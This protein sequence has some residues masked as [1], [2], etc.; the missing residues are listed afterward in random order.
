MSRLAAG[1]LAYG[2]A[3]CCVLLLIASYSERVP[4]VLVAQPPPQIV[5]APFFDHRAPE[6]PAVVDEDSADNQDDK[7][8]ILPGQFASPGQLRSVYP[9]YYLPN[10][11]SSDSWNDENGFSWSPYGHYSK[12]FAVPH[13][14]GPWHIPY[15]FPD[16]RKVLQKKKNSFRCAVRDDLQEH[17]CHTN[18][19]LEA[20]APKTKWFVCLYVLN[21]IVFLFSIYATRIIVIAV[22]ETR[23]DPGRC[24]NS[25]LI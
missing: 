1:W 10:A 24:A 12:P 15:P 11:R 7:E 22:S 14:E 18:R 4:S 21:L 8:D 17:M 19:V 3:V 5:R 16:Y 23:W 6:P 13:S 25:A 20:R 9:P 2:S